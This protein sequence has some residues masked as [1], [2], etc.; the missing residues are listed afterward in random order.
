MGCPRKDFETI[1]NEDVDYYYFEWI[2]NDEYEWMKWLNG[3]DQKG[4]T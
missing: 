4:K 2:K 1:L 3:R